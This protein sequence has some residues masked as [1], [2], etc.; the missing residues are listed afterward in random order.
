MTQLIV[1]LLEK[2]KKKGSVNTSAVLADG[3]GENKTISLIMYLTI[4]SNLSL[5]V[6]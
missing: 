4:T 3:V 6:R 1:S 2:K 5:K